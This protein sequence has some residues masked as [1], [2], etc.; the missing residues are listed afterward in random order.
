VVSAEEWGPAAADKPVLVVRIC[1]REYTHTW[2]HVGAM[3]FGLFV[4]QEGF[5]APWDPRKNTGKEA[6]IGAR[7]TFCPQQ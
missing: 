4:F 7:I 5:V 3:R 1:E 6:G 2:L